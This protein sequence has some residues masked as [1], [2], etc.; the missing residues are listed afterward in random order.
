MA[1]KRDE[2][3]TGEKRIDAVFALS[4]VPRVRDPGV[5]HSA[6]KKTT[7]DQYGTNLLYYKQIVF[8]QIVTRPTLGRDCG[9]QKGIIV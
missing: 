4:H 2:M 8:R 9:V 6:E 7:T 5:Q 1:R 3:T